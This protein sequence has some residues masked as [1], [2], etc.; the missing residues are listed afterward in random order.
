ML[1]PVNKLLLVSY[2]VINYLWCLHIHG[3][4]LRV[5]TYYPNSLKSVKVDGSQRVHH[6]LRTVYDCL[7]AVASYIRNIT[8]YHGVFTAN[9]NDL[10]RDSADNNDHIA[11]TLRAFYGLLRTKTSYY[12]HLTCGYGCFTKMYV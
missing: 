10:L 3:F 5:L 6:F 2:E 12:K 11:N 7:R 8:S 4:F 9:F 1:N